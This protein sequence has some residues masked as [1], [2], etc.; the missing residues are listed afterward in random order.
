MIRKNI[1]QKHP[2]R[3]MYALF[4]LSKTLREKCPNTAFF[5]A[6][7]FLYSDWIRRFTPFLRFAQYLNTFHALRT[8]SNLMYIQFSSVHA[9]ITG[10]AFLEK[11]NTCFSRK[12]KY[13]HA[14][15]DISNLN[16]IDFVHKVLEY[17]RLREKAS[18]LVYIATNSM[19]HL[20]ISIC[21]W[22]TR[23]LKQGKKNIQ[24]P[25]RILDSLNSLIT[26]YDY[27][28]CL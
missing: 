2:L 11:D 20:M 27:R 25:K 16:L 18:S 14:K 17:L 24:L 12:K 19:T 28:M 26:A 9:F 4:E 13:L 22:E 15:I 7:I 21:V 8:L 1:G 10:K 6:R 23:A 5:L 3:F